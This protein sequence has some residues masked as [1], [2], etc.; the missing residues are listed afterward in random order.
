MQWSESAEH[1]SGKSCRAGYEHGDES[2]ASI[3]ARVLYSS[4]ISMC[5][6]VSST[7]KKGLGGEKGL[8][9][10]CL[11]YF[12]ALVER[13]LNASEFH[14]TIAECYAPSSAVVAQL[15]WPLKSVEIGKEGSLNEYGRFFAC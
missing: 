13:S 10:S 5:F 6:L 1:H 12:W 7:L 2:C 14:Y 4:Y 3:G 11:V 8:L 9:G 15:T